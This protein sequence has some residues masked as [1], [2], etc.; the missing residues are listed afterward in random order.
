MKHCPSAYL[1]RMGTLSQH[2]PAC[3]KTLPPML[4]LTS[5]FVLNTAAEIKRESG[6]LGIL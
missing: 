1:P 5:A 2:L 3:A 4:L 6:L